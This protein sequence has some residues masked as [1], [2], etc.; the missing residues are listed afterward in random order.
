MHAGA[1]RSSLDVMPSLR[2]RV[3]SGRL[4]MDE[5]TDLPDGTEVELAP[6]E[7]D[8][9]PAA[10]ARIEEAL[11]EALLDLEAGDAGV[12][13]FAFLAELGAR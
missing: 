13:A 4:R 11:D 8:E 7:V 10:R 6:V 1:P 9:S 5:P 3:V 12:D 2:A